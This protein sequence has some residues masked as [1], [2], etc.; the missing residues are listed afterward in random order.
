M[1][2][3]NSF[4]TVAFTGNTQLTKK[5]ME[6]TLPHSKVVALFGLSSDELSGK[7]NSLDL[8]EF[9]EEH[10]IKLFSDNDWTEFRIYCQKNGVDSVITIGD[11][12][13]IPKT[14]IDS[15][16]VI[17]NHG[18]VLP[19]VP[20][21]ASLVWGR[22]LNSGE[23]GVSIMKIVEKVDA[24]DIL[25]TKTFQYGDGFTEAEFVET[26]DNLTVECLVDVLRGDYTITNN[27]KYDVRVAKHA[28]S[29]TAVN[30]LRYCLENNLCV[31]M[32]PRTPDDSVIDPNWSDE[33]IEVFKIA[34]NTPY[35][36]WKEE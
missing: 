23:W 30:V 6:A 14:I 18:A 28:D 25:K 16:D 2:E 21:G 35:P 20:G 15:F 10:D 1:V 17:G 12:R 7:T 31:Y 24:G 9:C 11:S 4:S 36:K 27:R 3:V 13:I 32:P 33:F 26:C 22:L 8:S 5:C 19:Y 34:Q 29:E